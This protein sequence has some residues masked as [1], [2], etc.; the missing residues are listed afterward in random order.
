MQI[1]QLEFKP[2]VTGFTHSAFLMLN[3]ENDQEWFIAM[4]GSYNMVDV[5]PRSLYVDNS[6]NADEV[7]VLSY[8]GELNKIVPPRGQLWVSVVGFSNIKIVSG[9]G[10]AYLEITDRSVPDFIFQRT[11]GFTN[12]LPTENVSYAN[13]N[14]LV[15][16]DVLGRVQG[17]YAQVFANNNIATTANAF[18]VATSPTWPNPPPGVT[19]FTS[20]EYETL[21][22]QTSGGS[23]LT[24]SA[25]STTTNIWEHSVGVDRSNTFLTANNAQNYS[26]IETPSKFLIKPNNQPQLFSVDKTSFNVSTL[27]A[28]AAG[29]TSGGVAIGI[30]GVLIADSETDDSF[31]YMGGVTGVNTN[32]R[33]ARFD[34]SGVLVTMGPAIT[35]SNS[36]WTAVTGSRV[37]NQ[38]HKFKNGN[39]L[40]MRNVGNIVSAVMTD[41]NFNLI[42]SVFD[43]TGLSSY[44]PAVSGS[45]M[46]TAFELGD[47]FVICC[48]LNTGVM[49]FIVFDENGFVGN[50]D[51]GTANNGFANPSMFVKSGNRLYGL[52][53]NNIQRFVLS[54]LDDS[55]NVDSRT[56]AVGASQTQQAGIF[57]QDR[58]VFCC[59]SNYCSVYDTVDDVWFD[60]EATT[61]RI[62][63]YSNFYVDIGN[64]LVGFNDNSNTPTIVDMFLRKTVFGVL[65]DSQNVAIT[66]QHQIT[67]SYPG[68]T[69]FDYNGST[70]IG[71]R[72][73]V[74]GNTIVLN[75]LTP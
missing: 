8:D 50:Y 37:M 73:I 43:Q 10:V 68:S 5:V 36:R 75:G 72:G 51:G 3:F 12:Y 60:G 6:L 11:D 45:G 2:N 67:R 46:P 41:N 69:S 1:Y 64:K 19:P 22:I 39:Y 13:L 74:F 7:R 65:K 57:V 66:G 21:T 55:L 47:Y 38:G 34:S 9:A 49:R 20:S 28:N 26:V 18:P 23:Y 42:G 52:G 61:N 58:Y 40:F 56:A 31:V 44:S 30:A 15:T 48:T 24:V 54:W 63:L 71:N 59:A 14:D 27:I 25:S 53:M 32:V 29:F 62:P 16:V 17:T 70:P 4:R 35:V 33:A